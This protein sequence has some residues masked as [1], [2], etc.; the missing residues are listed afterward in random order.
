MD[1]YTR[2]YTL[3][4]NTYTVE[5]GFIMCDIP[6]KI[7]LFTCFMCVFQQFFLNRDYPERKLKKK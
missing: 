1:I 4:F 6:L 7:F 5:K 2:A 3:H